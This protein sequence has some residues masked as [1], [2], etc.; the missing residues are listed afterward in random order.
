MFTATD[1]VFH[2][3]NYVDLNRDGLLN[4]RL[5]ADTDFIAAKATLMPQPNQHSSQPVAEDNAAVAY[6]KVLAGAGASLFRDAIDTHLIEELQSLGKKGVII[7]NEAAIGGQPVI[8]K[9]T[10]Q[11]DSDGDGMPDNWELKVKLDPKDP[12]DAQKMDNK[13]GYTNIEKYINS[14]VVW[15]IR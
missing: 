1:H 9:E 7:V 15:G 2:R 5:V 11:K 14:L 12:G 10:M 8:N 3:G 4:G 13:D 6:Q